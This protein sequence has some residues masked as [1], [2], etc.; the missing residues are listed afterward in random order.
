MIRIKHFYARIIINKSITI[1]IG[2]LSITSSITNEQLW[3]NASFGN[4]ITLP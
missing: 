4:V 1:M 2:R 3:S